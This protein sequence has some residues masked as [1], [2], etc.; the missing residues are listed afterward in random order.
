MPGRARARGAKTKSV[1]FG[2]KGTNTRGKGC[3]GEFLTKQGF[4]YDD[5]RHMVMVI[6]IIILTSGQM[7]W[8]VDECL[9][10]A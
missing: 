2:P 1:K 5:N 4:Y 7:R 6:V 8:A 3:V 10:L 9:P